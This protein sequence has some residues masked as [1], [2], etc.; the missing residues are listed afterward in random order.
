VLK[1]EFPKGGAIFIY[2]LAMI[3]LL[4]RPQ[5]LAGKRA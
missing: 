2:A 5:G 1:V 3:I 4:A